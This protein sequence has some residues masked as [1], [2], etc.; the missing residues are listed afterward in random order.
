MPRKPYNFH[1]VYK[2]TCLI[3]NR[4]YIGIHSTDNVNDGYIGSGTILWFS[5]RKHGKTNHIREILEFLPDRKTL[6]EKEI[7]LIAQHKNDPLCMNI[8]KGGE[9]FNSTHS[10]QSK[11]KISEKLKG[12]TYIEIHG[13]TNV[14]NEKQKRAE[15]TKKYW[16]NLTPKEKEI[17]GYSQRGKRK[18]FALQPELKCPHCGF[19]GRGSCMKRWHFDNCKPRPYSK[20]TYTNNLI[21]DVNDGR[22]DAVRLDKEQ[23]VDRQRLRL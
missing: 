15:A 16:A 23:E 8:A 10:E 13:Q 2:T 1:Y 21:A 14:E 18:K 12:K 9:W 11:A 7:E 22:N 19:V 3:T 5:I 17:R 20:A 4:F 6:N